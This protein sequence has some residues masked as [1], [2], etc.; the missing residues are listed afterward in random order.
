MILNWYH[1]S[2]YLVI[3]AFSHNAENKIDFGDVFCTRPCFHS[4]LWIN[5]PCNIDSVTVL[6]NSARTATN[7]VSTSWVEVELLFNVFVE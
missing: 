2:Y 6:R 3:V 4:V 7:R 1:K 5:F